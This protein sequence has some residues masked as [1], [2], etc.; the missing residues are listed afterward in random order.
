MATNFEQYSTSQLYM[1]AQQY[2]FDV[3]F[4]ANDRA[5]LLNFCRQGEYQE[6]ARR[7]EA[8]SS[9][10][11]YAMPDQSPV[12]QPFHAEDNPDPRRIRPFSSGEAPP[13]PRLTRE[14]FD[15]ARRYLNENPKATQREAQRYARSVCR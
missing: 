3:T 15:A 1:L 10:S 2:G 4:Y 12:G 7:Y 13:E 6:H 8:A 14:Q 11:R 5:G 9:V